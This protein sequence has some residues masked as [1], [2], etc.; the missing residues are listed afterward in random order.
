MVPAAKEQM[1]RAMIRIH[2]L[3]NPDPRFW[4]AKNK[5]IEVENKFKHISF[6]VSS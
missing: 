6:K 4:L 2:I 5:N 3:L 1:Y